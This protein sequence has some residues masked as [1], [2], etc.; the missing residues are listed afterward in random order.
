L[1]QF[2][3]LLVCQASRWIPLPALRSAVSFPVGKIIFS[4]VVSQIADTIV[5]SG[6]IVVAYLHAIRART[7]ED[8]SNDAMNRLTKSIAV[9]TKIHDLVSLGYTGTQATIGIA[10][11]PTYPSVSGTAP[12]L[13]Q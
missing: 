9:A 4:R 6:P 10:E 7:N 8:F 13:P 1:L 5:V 3:S 2:V 12:L 11:N